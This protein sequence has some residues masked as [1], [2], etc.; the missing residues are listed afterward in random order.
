MT[1]TK[2]FLN[3]GESVELEEETA[4]K[5]RGR[6]KQVAEEVHRQHHL[7]GE[8]EPTPQSAI[9]FDA[10]VKGYLIGRKDMFE[11]F[12][13]ELGMENIYHEQQREIQRKRS[14]RIDRKIIRR[15]RQPASHLLKHLFGEETDHD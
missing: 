1:E 7:H 15:Y 2:V 3:S 4:R 9:A 13:K 6:A 8:T 5:L 14:E 12:I 10:I 11:E